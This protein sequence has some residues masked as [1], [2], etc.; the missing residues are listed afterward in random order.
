MY[1]DVGE[2]EE[3][4]TKPGPCL[5]LLVASLQPEQRFDF[6]LALRI[7]TGQNGLYGLWWQ[8]TF[9]RAHGCAQLR[10][11]GCVRELRSDHVARDLD[12]LRQSSV[13]WT[14]KGRILRNE[15]GGKVFVNDVRFDHVV[16]NR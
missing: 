14:E 15:H 3:R 16:A 1:L 6:Q 4:T 13:T 7:Q 5:F 12:R 9:R 11:R 10:S 8:R 2:I